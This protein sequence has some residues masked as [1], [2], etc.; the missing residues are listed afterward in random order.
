MNGCAKLLPCLVLVCLSGCTLPDLLF[1]MFGHGYSAGGTL[2]SEKKAH[3][4]QIVDESQRFGSFRSKD[5]QTGSPW[6]ASGRQ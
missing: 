5:H 2:P 1:G 6:D 3:Y 4:D